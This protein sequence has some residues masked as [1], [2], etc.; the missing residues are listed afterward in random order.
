MSQVATGLGGSA[1]DLASANNALRQQHLA[2]AEIIDRDYQDHCCSDGKGSHRQRKA[3]FMAM[4][5]VL[6]FWLAENR[7]AGLMKARQAVERRLM[8]ECHVHMHLAFLQWGRTVQVIPPPL[9]PVSDSDSESERSDH[10]TSDED[11]QRDYEATQHYA[12]C[13]I[14]LNRFR[15]PTFTW[16]SQRGQYEQANVAADVLTHADAKFKLLR[17]GFLARLK[18]RLSANVTE[19]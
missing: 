19:S 13:G 12:L 7:L 17:R 2:A 16:T 9:V 15:L 3:L 14:R 5:Q 6:R 1:L 8:E 4:F 11:S 10:E 18:Q